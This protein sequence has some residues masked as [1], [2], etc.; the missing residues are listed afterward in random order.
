M[1]IAEIRPNLTVNQAFCRAAEALSK[2]GTIANPI[3]SI[4]WV[5][6]QKS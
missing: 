1:Q 3:N 2:R 4:C 6:S 5:V